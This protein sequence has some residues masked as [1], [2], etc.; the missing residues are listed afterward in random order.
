[1]KE[2]HNNGERGTSG[3]SKTGRTSC[4]RK[5]RTGTKERNEKARA[6]NKNIYYV[7]SL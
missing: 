6:L 2:A 4:E 7:N 5:Q 3:G 1:M